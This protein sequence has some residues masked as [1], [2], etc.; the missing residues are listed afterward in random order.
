MD[1]VADP[2]ALARAAA[3]AGIADASAASSG[4]H[5]RSP[6]SSSSSAGGRVAC[7]SALTGEGV[8]D[9]VALIEDHVSGSLCVVEAVVP[10][11]EGALVAE[12]R[13]FGF[14]DEERF[15]DSGVA[16]R[17]HVPLSLVRR[18]DGY[19]VEPGAWEALVATSQGAEQLAR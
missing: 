1:A 19:R 16:I 18:M 14:V 4:G 7:V 10:F 11:N 6:S 13:R 3:A 5:G 2:A 8:S 12:I 15:T 17:A 9:L